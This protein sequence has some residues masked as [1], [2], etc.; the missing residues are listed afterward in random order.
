ME[1][2]TSLELTLIYVLLGLMALMGTLILFLA[3]KGY[4]D[5]ISKD[6]ED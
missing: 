2:P 5:S 3:F 6:K 4:I 1:Q